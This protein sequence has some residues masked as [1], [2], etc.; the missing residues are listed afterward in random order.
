MTA[1][2]WRERL[3]RVLDAS[4]ATSTANQ[5][6]HSWR[7][8]YPDSY[9]DGPCDCVDLLLDDLLNL[10]EPLWRVA[11]AARGLLEPDLDAKGRRYVVTSHEPDMVTF[12]KALAALDAREE[13]S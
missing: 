7:C 8:E 2:P 13:T 12:R 11:E 3:R 1:G 9:G 10:V 6:L 4:G 5:G